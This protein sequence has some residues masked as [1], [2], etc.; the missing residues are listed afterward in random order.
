MSDVVGAT[1]SRATLA[2]H[3]QGLIAGLMACVVASVALVTVQGRWPNPPEM[4][5]AEPLGTRMW[6]I[7]LQHPDQVI[8]REVEAP[9]IGGSST[10]RLRVALDRDYHGEAHL[11]ATVAGVDLGRMFASGTQRGLSL[12]TDSLELIFESRLIT[13]RETVE[14]VL[15]QPVPD[16]MLRIVVVGDAR[17]GLRTRD[18]M[19]FGTGG[20]W[21]A[22][23]PLAR[24][25]AMVLALPLVWLDGV[26]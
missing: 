6:S 1:A 4:L 7:T 10:A 24:S 16:P 3:R 13:G 11:A 26:Y 5:K 14:V 20:A 21:F 19:A 17:G 8:R 25:G 18:A 9:K 15:R 12:G 2:G 23:V 22:G